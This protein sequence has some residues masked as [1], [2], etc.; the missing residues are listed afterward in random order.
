MNDSE[1]LA[2][3]T[4]I[5]TLAEAAGVDIHLLWD[6]ADECPQGHYLDPAIYNVGIGYLCEQC[7]TEYWN[8]HM[9]VNEADWYHEHAANED[10]PAWHPEWR[11]G[12]VP[13]DFTQASVL[14]AVVEA[15]KYDVEW[16][17]YDTGT[18]EGWNV[19]IGRPEVVLGIGSATKLN[20]ALRE[21][22]YVALEEGGDGSDGP[23]KE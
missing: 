8:T 14:F 13:K 23:R 6:A 9:E 20:E 10:N 3:N 15:L 2:I 4:R 5:A 16:W 11:V 17:P 18:E 22:L 19:R 21:A 1:R 12:R 7:D